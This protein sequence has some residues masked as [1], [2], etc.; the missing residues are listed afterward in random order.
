MAMIKYTDGNRKF[1][2]I[3][4]SKFEQSAETNDFSNDTSMMRQICTSKA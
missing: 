1:I 4:P 3:P 2:D